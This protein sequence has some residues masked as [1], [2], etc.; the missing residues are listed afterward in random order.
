MVGCLTAG[1]LGSLTFRHDEGF[2][3]VDYGGNLVLLDSARRIYVFGADARA[4]PDERTTPDSVR[5]G[6]HCGAFRRSLVARVHVVA[7]GQR[8][9]RGADKDW[10]QADHRT[11]G[12]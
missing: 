1:M 2:Q 3:P 9:R 4:F 11:S 10:V 8:Q 12:I 5:M 7:L 6:Q